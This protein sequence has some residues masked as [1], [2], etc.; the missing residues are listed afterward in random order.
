M[1]ST[2][3]GV[4]IGENFDIFFQAPVLGVDYLTTGWLCAEEREDVLG[5]ILNRREGWVRGIRGWSGWR[6]GGGVYCSGADGGHHKNCVIPAGS[7]RQQNTVRLV[8]VTNTTRF[9]G[10]ANSSRLVGNKHHPTC[11]RR[12]HCLLCRKKTLPAL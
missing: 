4:M 10:D 3:S 2:F 9:V 5:G 1:H 12:K 7:K 11:R 6:M 8:G